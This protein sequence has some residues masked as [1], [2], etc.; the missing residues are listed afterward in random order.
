MSKK[1]FAIVYGRIEKIR[2]HYPN[3]RWRSPTLEITSGKV[4]TKF[5]PKREQFEQL[6]SVLPSIGAF[7][8]KL[9]K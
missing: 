2:L 8:G 1:S 3:S 4:Q 7:K 6:S 5:L 9:E